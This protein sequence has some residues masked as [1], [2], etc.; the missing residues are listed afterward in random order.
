MLT[1]QVQETYTQLERNTNCLLLALPEYSGLFPIKVEY[2]LL[3]YSL[4]IIDWM[5]L[6]FPTSET[7]LFILR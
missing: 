7:D 2:F 4:T 6:I 5:S 3:F 1:V